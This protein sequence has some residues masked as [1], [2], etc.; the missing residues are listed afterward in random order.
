M[1][2]WNVFKRRRPLDDQLDSE[3]RFHIDKLTEE[4]IAVGLTADQAL[5]ENRLRTILLTVFAV[6]AVSLASIGLYGTLSYFV[7]VRKREV[8][9]RLALG[10]VPVQI[11]T[12]FLF[13][14]SVYQSSDV[15]PACVWP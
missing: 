8:G 6:T 3:L 5:A 11:V 9:L 1:P 2:W 15:L 10:A 14:G 12:R 7:I 4:K 13:K